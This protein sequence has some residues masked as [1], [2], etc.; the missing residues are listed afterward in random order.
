[1]NLFWKFA[2]SNTKN[3]EQGEPVLN[4]R[5]NVPVFIYYF[6]SYLQQQMM[7]KMFL[8][9]TLTLMLQSQSH[10]SIEI[11]KEQWQQADMLH[12]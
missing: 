8:V 7:E 10:V 12:I 2:L 11:A 3:S 9:L 6:C 1:M 4:V 5:L